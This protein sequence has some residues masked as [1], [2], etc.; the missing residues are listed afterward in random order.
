MFNMRL[1]IGDFHRQAMALQACYRDAQRYQ[2]APRPCCRGRLAGITTYLKKHGWRGFPA[3]SPR[4]AVKIT[5]MDTVLFDLGKV[6]LDWDPRYFYRTR[7]GGDEAAMERFL[8]EAAPPAWVIEMDAGKPMAQ[9][10]AERQRLYPQYAAELALWSEGWHTMLRREI[11]GTA[12]IVADLKAR[13]RRLYALTNFSAETW[14]SAMARCPS[15]ALFEDAIVSGEHG[16]VKPDPRFYELA[17]HR[18]RIDP[19]KTVFVDDM[20]VNVEAARGCGL[21]ALHFSGP[22]K[23]RVELAALALL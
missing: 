10:I 12:A 7:F 11:T 2:F 15:L 14:P 18:C 3:V 4:P 19:A 13:G 21:L 6:L 16:L 23:L 17:I 1:L 22:E 9:A 5:G 8:T 20:M